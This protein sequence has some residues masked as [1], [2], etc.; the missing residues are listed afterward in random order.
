MRLY[1]KTDK[2]KILLLCT[3][4]FCVITA[5]SFSEDLE[6]AKSID[7]QVERIRYLLYNKGFLNSEASEEIGS[8]ASQFSEAGRF[9]LY[10]QFKMRPGFFLNPPISRFAFFPKFEDTSL[11]VS[12]SVLGIIGMGSWFY[13]A[14]V[15]SQY[16]S[17]P[18]TT[19]I[20]IGG[21]LVGLTATAYF[22]GLPIWEP[23][24]YDMNIV[25]RELRSVLNDKG[26]LGD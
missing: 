1:G 22:V 4:L 24:A 19:S 3:T 17:G 18:V 15:G 14:M 25:N 5:H 23:R 12:M 7:D 11:K 13:V 2:S 20:G 21:F 6:S 8:L 16:D 26:N 10:E 9:Q